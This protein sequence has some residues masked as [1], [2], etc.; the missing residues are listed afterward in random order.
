MVKTLYKIYTKDAEIIDDEYDTYI[1]VAINCKVTYLGSTRC[2]ISIIAYGAQIKFA[3]MSHC[4]IDIDSYNGATIICNG[5]ERSLIQLYGNFYELNLL[6]VTKCHITSYHVMLCNIEKLNIIF[7]GHTTVQLYNAR[8]LCVQNM[9]CSNL[10]I[11]NYDEKYVTCSKFGVRID[12]SDVNIG[13]LLIID[14]LIDFNVRQSN[15]NFNYGILCASYIDTH[16]MIK[17]VKSYIDVQN[18]DGVAP[19]VS[20]FNPDKYNLYYDQSL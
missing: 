1:I 8:H 16:N 18:A 20:H 14:K 7:M 10:T 5:I 4:N 13:Q 11:E 6:S 12:K 3:L 15:I 2:R 17:N 9:E 19:K